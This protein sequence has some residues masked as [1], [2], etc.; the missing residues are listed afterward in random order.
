MSKSEK[1]ITFAVAVVLGALALA[2][3]AGAYYNLPDLR[4]GFFGMGSEF[5]SP[6]G[7]TLDQ[8]EYEVLMPFAREATEAVSVPTGGATADS[9]DAVA[10]GD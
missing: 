8:L 4:H 1:R 5:G 7:R 10:G 3:P 9:P 6:D 2:P